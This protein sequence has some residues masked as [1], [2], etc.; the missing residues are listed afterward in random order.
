MNESVA[1]RRAAATSGKLVTNRDLAKAGQSRRLNDLLLERGIS[2]AELARMTGLPPYT[3]SRAARGE[4]V[5]GVGI[6]SKIAKALDV[7]PASIVDSSGR[8][9][10]DDL[11][12]GVHSSQQ[13]DGTVWLR[14]NAYTTGL[15]HTLVEIL[16]ARKEGITG[17][18]L[19]RV[20]MAIDKFDD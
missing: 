9:G 6:I 3:I 8:H 12:P 13:G 18:Q 10:L 19:T 1:A 16:L 17:P 11:P 5:L 7:E 15:T 2:Q 20:L 4:N 14:V